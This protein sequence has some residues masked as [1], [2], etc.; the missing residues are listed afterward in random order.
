MAKKTCA[1][2][3]AGMVGSR[4][5]AFLD[6]PE[7]LEHDKDFKRLKRQCRISIEGDELWAWDDDK[8]A[9]RLFGD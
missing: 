3:G 7:E 5:I 1:K 6:D 8:E 4:R 9:S 2:P